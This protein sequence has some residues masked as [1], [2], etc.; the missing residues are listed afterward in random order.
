MGVDGIA[1]KVDVEITVGEVSTAL[2]VL[3]QDAKKIARMKI[4]NTFVKW[5][6]IELDAQLLTHLTQNVLTSCL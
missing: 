4:A 6:F 5:F 1:I 2:C 3:W